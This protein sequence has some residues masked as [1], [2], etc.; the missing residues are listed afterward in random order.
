MDAHGRWLFWACFIA[1]VATAF[2]FITRIQVI[3]EW[4]R[5]FRLSETQKGEILGAGIWPFAVS[6]ILVSLVVDRIGYG[7][8]MVFAFVCHAGSAVVLICAQ[9][10]WGLYIG[11]FILALGNGTVEAVINPVVATMFPRQKTKWLSILHAGWPGGLVLAG[12][13]AIS[14]NETGVVGRF[15]GGAVSWNWK[16]GLILIPAAIYGV[17]MVRCRFPVQERVAAGVPYRT[18][19]QEAGIVGCLIATSLIVWEVTRIF[20]DW[21]H[22]RLFDGWEGRN[23]FIARIVI[24]AVLSIPFSLYTR[25]MGKPLFSILLA[26]MIMAA[27]TEVSSD[28]WIKDLMGPEVSKLGGWGLDGT[29][30]LVYSAFIMMVLRFCAGPLVERLNPLGVLAA[31]SVIATV[32]LNSLSIAQGGFILVAA[33]LYGVG[34]TFFWPCMLGVAS[35]RFPRGGAMTINTIGAVGV[36]GVGIIGNPWLGY[37]QDRQITRDL[38]ATNSALYSQV[39]GA[40]KISV[41]GE[42]ERIDP[43]KVAALP[44]EPKQVVD[45]IKESAKKNVLWRVAILPA[46]LAVC[47]LGL[48][49][50]FRSKGGYSA[51]DLDSNDT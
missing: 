10:Y 37:M 30:V 6:I 1:L 12:L 4:A 47:Y 7:T 33:T 17:M 27:I 34:Q 11:S 49:L 29:W 43:D 40:E 13:L 19:L 9:G 38:Q 31:T 8:A 16:I 44:S 23:V 42:Y 36:L 20:M 3:D 41:F 5:S 50:Y 32:G 51:V 25:A 24:I 35:E 14:L 45:S 22:V 46:V 28:S 15:A 21:D 48:I 39:R 26:L 18:M 2:G